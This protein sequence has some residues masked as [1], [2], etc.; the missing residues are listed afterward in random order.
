M[1]AVE[2]VRDKAARE[3]FPPEARVAQRVRQAALRRGVILRP[4]ADLIVVC[5]P[6]VVTREQIDVIVNALGEAIAEVAGELA[7]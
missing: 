6:L 3:P 5:P 4:G 1:A 2:L 7:A